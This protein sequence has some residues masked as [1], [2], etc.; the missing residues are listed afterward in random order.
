MFL[1]V[2]GLNKQLK[3]ARLF[4]LQW[5]SAYFAHTG[6]QVRWEI[7]K[8]VAKLLIMYICQLANQFENFETKLATLVPTKLVKLVNSR[9]GFI[10][11]RSSDYFRS[12]IK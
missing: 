3:R 5:I 4:K 11:W 7:L 6:C 10:N 9:V 2:K 1:G 12:E 8:Y